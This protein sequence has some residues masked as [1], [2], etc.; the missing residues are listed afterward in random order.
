MLV[1]VWGSGPLGQLHKLPSF[2]SPL[3]AQNFFLI[4][5]GGE[6]GIFLLFPFEIKSCYVTQETLKLAVYPK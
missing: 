1:Y 4:W 3:N 5:G 2:E 6:L